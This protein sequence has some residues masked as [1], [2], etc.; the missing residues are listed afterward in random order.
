MNDLDC[1]EFVEQVTAFLE[2]ALDPEAEQRLVDHLAL[3]DG[4]ERYLDQV[5]RSVT[6]LRDLPADALPDETRAALLEA[7]RARTE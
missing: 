3:C 5:R 2:H 7:F 4:C 1:R 6:D